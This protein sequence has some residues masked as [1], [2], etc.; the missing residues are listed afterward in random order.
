MTPLE[1]T[2]LSLATWRLSSLLTR[3]DG[4]FYI[5]R[6]LREL[7]GIVHDEDGN[8]IVVPERFFALL[9]SCSWCVSIWVAFFVV[10]FWYIMPGVLF[11]V[12]LVLAL[13]AIAIFVDKII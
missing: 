7:N 10:L 4:P 5:F 8:A 1:F 2:I 9:L 13:S 11:I 12:S 6:R 3:E